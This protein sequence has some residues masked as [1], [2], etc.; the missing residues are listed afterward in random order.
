MGYAYVALER[1]ALECIMLQQGELYKI[2]SEEFS[3]AGD[4]WYDRSFKGREEYDDSLIEIVRDCYSKGSSLAC[5]REYPK[6]HVSRST[7]CGMVTFYTQREVAVSIPSAGSR[8]RKAVAKPSRRLRERLCFNPKLQWRASISRG[9]LLPSCGF[10]APQLQF[11]NNSR[12]ISAPA[13][14]RQEVPAACATTESKVASSS[15]AETREG[16][17]SKSGSPRRNRESKVDQTSGPAHDPMDISGEEDERTSDPYLSY[18]V[19]SGRAESRAGNSR[20]RSSE[21]KLSSRGMRETESIMSRRSRIPVGDSDVS[22]GEYSELHDEDDSELHDEN[23]DSSESHPCSSRRP[24]RPTPSRRE[25]IDL[26]DERG[27]CL[28]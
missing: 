21:S 7:G 1:G 12:T 15:S 27:N 24:G 13:C 28:V 8:G 6:H 17:E 22:E 2:T 19:A 3:G 9:P 5:R 10:P 20:Q 23:S 26:N 11:S 16:K 18:M 25:V 14:E 4:P